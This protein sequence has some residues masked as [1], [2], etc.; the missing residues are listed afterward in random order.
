M[1]ISWEVVNGS[2]SSGKDQLMLEDNA[3]CLFIPLKVLLTKAEWF[4]GSICVQKAFSF[5]FIFPCCTL[6]TFEPILMIDWRNSSQI[7]VYSTILP[8]CCTIFLR[9]VQDVLE[10]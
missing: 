5:L 7:F 2:C 4:H 6:G 1:S 8:N 9:R 3:I 10:E